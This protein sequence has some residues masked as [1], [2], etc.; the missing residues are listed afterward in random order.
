MQIKMSR[1]YP[2]ANAG[3]VLSRLERIAIVAAS[4]GVEAILVA[5]LPRASLQVI[6]CATQV[7]RTVALPRASLRRAEPFVGLALVFVTLRKLVTVQL[8]CVPVTQQPQMGHRVGIPQV[9]LALQDNALRVINNA[10][11]SWVRL[12]KET[13]HT[14]VP[15]QAVRSLALLLN[16]VPTCAILCNR[17]SSTARLVKAVASARTVSARASRL[18]RRLRAGLTTI[19][20]WSLL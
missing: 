11:P 19:R 10:K 15:H 14:H 8:Q 12:H 16:S 9:F 7:M 6:R 2:E 1:P 17:T 4:P 18:G 5:T 13:T 20:H 3:T